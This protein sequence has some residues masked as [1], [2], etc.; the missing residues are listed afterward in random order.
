MH[1]ATNPQKGHFTG[2]TR[3]EA[4]SW[5]TNQYCSVT[6]DELVHAFLEAANFF[7]ISRY[8]TNIL[9]TN[10]LSLHIKKI[11]MAIASGF[12]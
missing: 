5:L 10:F 6:S 11:L 2:S 1:G 4:V 12:S 3:V 7:Q 8:F 9:Q